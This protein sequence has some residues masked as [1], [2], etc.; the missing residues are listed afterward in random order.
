MEDIVSHLTHQLA[1]NSI[2]Q[3][4][5]IIKE[6]AE[7]GYK[8]LIIKRETTFEDYTAKCNIKYCGS[9]SDIEVEI[10]VNKGYEVFE[11]SKVS[12]YLAKDMLS[13]LKGE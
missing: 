7:Q 12:E 11:L 10:F 9:N 8:Y 6:I 13:K 2:E 1:Q 3:Q 4:E 5:K